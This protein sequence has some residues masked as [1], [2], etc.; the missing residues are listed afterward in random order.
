MNGT[1]PSDLEVK[2]GAHRELSTSAEHR[3]NLV[4][5]KERAGAH[6][7]ASSSTLRHDRGEG[8]EISVALHGHLN[9]IDT[10]IP[11]GHRQFDAARDGVAAKDRH[12][13]PIGEDGLEEFVGVVAHDVLVSSRARGKSAV[14]R[15]VRTAR[16]C[17]RLNLSG[18]SSPSR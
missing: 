7:F 1:L 10:K 3:L 14:S 11:C 9:E 8:V 15:R 16:S 2:A 6:H 17:P 4:S 13:W 5:A 18:A 12:D